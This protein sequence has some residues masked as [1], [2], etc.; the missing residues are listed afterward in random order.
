MDGKTLLTAANGSTGKAFVTEIYKQLIGNY[1][2]F[3]KMDL[4]CRLGFVASE[5]LLKAEGTDPYSTP[6]SRAVALIG[7]SGSICADRNYLQSFVNPNDY[8]PSPERFVYTLPNIVTGEIAIRN[9]YHGETAFY[10]LPWRDND[11][12][13]QLLCSTLADQATKSIIGG[14]LNCDDEEHFEADI[15]IIIKEQ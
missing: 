13:R 8:Y 15:N 7:H 5:L 11:I 10:M 12:I 1:P 2:R 6:E 9:H 4:L 3:Y 14:W